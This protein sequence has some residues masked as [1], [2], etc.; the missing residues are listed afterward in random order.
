MTA[1]GRSWEYQRRWSLIGGQ[2]LVP[3]PWLAT[4]TPEPSSG[5][6]A[7][8]SQPGK[9]CENT[10]G[11]SSEAASA[12]RIDNGRSSA[13][14]K[15]LMENLR[16]GSRD[17]DRWVPRGSASP[18]GGDSLCSIGARGESSTARTSREPASAGATHACSFAARPVDANALL[19]VARRPDQRLWIASTAARPAYQDPSGA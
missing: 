2:P 8:K 1:E 4:T 12:V 13:K 18:F 5:P 6:T 15:C 9:A 7:E 17:C 10:G 16:V 3:S 14:R 11:T 19:L